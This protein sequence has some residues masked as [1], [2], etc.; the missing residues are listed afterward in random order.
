MRNSYKIQKLISR[1][2]KAYYAIYKDQITFKDRNALIS[3]GKS[4]DRVKVVLVLIN[5]TLKNDTDLKVPI[6]Q[7]F[8]KAH[9]LDLPFETLIKLLLNHNRLVLLSDILKQIASLY[10]M[11]HHIVEFK[12]TTPLDISDN[13]KTEINSFLSNMIQ[14]TIIP[15]YNI[16][17]SLIAGFR[18]QSK[19]F[20]YENSLR[21]KLQTLTHLID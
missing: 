16:D 4:L 18:A 14:Q 7:N 6:I 20:L 1:Y 17:S 19:D 13:L 2:S 12:I 11:Q 5:N 21:K 3:I 10:D 15:H 9:D 8:F